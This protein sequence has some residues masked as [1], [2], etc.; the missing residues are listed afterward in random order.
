MTTPKRIRSR[1]TPSTSITASVPTPTTGWRTA[2]VP[3]PI[4]AS[5]SRRAGSNWLGRKNPAPRRRRAKAATPRW[6]LCHEHEVTLLLTAHH[7]DDQAET[8]LLQLLRGSGP[9]G[10]SGMDAANAAPELLANPA[11]V[12]AR[13]LLSASRKQLA[14]YVAEH[15]I[16]HINDESNDDPRFARNA[17]RHQVMPALAQAFPGFQERFAR[18]AQ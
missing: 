9:A 14:A 7:L 12:M 3:A 8:V 5:P 10:L 1:C 16:V 17:L 18:S 6:A 13:P 11:L 15:G 4:W 2:R